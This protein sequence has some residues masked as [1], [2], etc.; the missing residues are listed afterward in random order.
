MAAPEVFEPRGDLDRLELTIPLHSLDVGFALL[1]TGCS[2]GVGALA[3]GLILLAPWAFTTVMPIAMLAMVGLVF[4]PRISEQE[5]LELELTDRVLRL[6]H[7]PVG[8]EVALQLESIREV[9]LR[10]GSVWVEHEAGEERFWLDGAV[11]PHGPWLIDTVAK[12]SQR[13]RAALQGDSP[14]ALQDLLQGR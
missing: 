2:T 14:Q 8:R 5:T 12:A 10:E 13:R 3:V 6:R 1:L 4:V 11:V 7:R 9:R